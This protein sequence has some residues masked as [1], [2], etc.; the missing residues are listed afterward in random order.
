MT[1]KPASL[2]SDL[3]AQKGEAS[4][5]QVDPE[6]R[7]T[8][9]VAV[10][11]IEPGGDGGGDGRIKPEPEIIYLPEEEASTSSGPN[12]RLAV[13][14]LAAVA[15]IGGVA[16]A[17]SFN[18]SEPT[19]AP[20]APQ[21]SAAPEEPA[22]TPDLAGSTAPNAD[23]G[24]NEIT[25]IR[26]EV[27]DRDAAVATTGS[28]DIAANATPGPIPPGPAVEVL[29]PEGAELVTGSV[30]GQAQDET[31]ALRGAVEASEPAAPS[32]T[33][34]EAREPATPIVETAAAQAA[35][36]APSETASAATQAGAASAG[37]GAYLVQLGSVRSEAAAARE[38]T[39][40]QARHEG[41]L[42]GRALDL[43]KADLGDKGTYYRIR[44]GSFET[45]GDASAL[46][47]KL[48]AAGQ[49]CLVWRK[50]AS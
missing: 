7:A 50:P 34:L 17:V 29:T 22:A 31:A 40:L 20:V 14:A 6:A 38:W 21:F 13:G 11:A 45:K 12:L 23:V 3:L 41:L 24:A 36:D 27:F 44:T 10:A 48:K 30:G 19:I 26:Q 32:G 18:R 47:G 15:I 16:L 37:G 33:D 42:G 39:K 43:Q 35:V 46:C 1:R 8:G 28:S 2:S 5:T 9:P 49:D 25:G 4:P